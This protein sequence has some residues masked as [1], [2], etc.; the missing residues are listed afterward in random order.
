[1]WL[2]FLRPLIVRLT[3]HK[4]ILP[5]NAARAAEVLH[6]PTIATLGRASGSEDWDRNRAFIVS[7]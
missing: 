3:G 4:S 2:S 5:A 7:F 1:M 6:F